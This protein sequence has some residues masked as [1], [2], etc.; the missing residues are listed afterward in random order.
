[1]IR[2]LEY[3]IISYIIFALH[4]KLFM[5]T[6]F[7]AEWVWDLFHIYFCTIIVYV[8]ILLIY[9]IRI[10]FGLKKLDLKYFPLEKI[11]S[12][13][14][15]KNKKNIHPYAA[16]E[17]LDLINMKFMNLF[18]GIIFVATWKI[19]FIFF[20]SLMNLMVSL[21]IYP[22]LK[23]KSDNLES[24]ILF[25]YL[26]FLKLVCRLAIWAFGVNKIE[27]NYLC[28]NEWPK[29]IVSNHISAVDPLFFISEHACS[30]VA[31][32]SLSK[33]RMVGPSVLALK[34]V[35][36]YREKSEDR[37]IALESIKERQLLINAKQ[38]NY[39]SF[40]IFSEGTTSNGL[41]II[42]QKKGAF[43]SLL[44]ITPV[45]LIYDYDFYNPSY[46][47]IPFTWW[48][49]LSSSNYQG[50]TLRTYW[51]PK[52]YPPDK[53]QYPDLTDEERINIFHDEVSKIMFNHMKKYN[54]RAPKDVDDY[55]DWPGSLRFKLEYFQ[56]ALG[57]VAT[58]H[59]NKEKNLSEK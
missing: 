57:N 7:Y 23:G 21:L 8:N 11:A 27:N 38:N 34:C 4:V 41:Q 6:V 3:H 53:A 48:I 30:F 17:R 25:L 52:V 49:F 39:P 10:Y 12:C 46:D 42:E 47:I 54:P 58:K 18:Y 1:M 45:L 15:Y 9:G 56:N 28:D 50:S 2:K 37:K 16:F 35:L 32:K 5:H 40:V 24:P 13:T 55:N 59:L 43:N 51:L 19:A 22:F 20:L 36:V 26:K 33:D 14:N 29:N 31:K 44:P